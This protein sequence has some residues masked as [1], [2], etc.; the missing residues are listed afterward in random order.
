[1]HVQLFHLAH[2]QNLHRAQYDVILVCD[3]IGDTA[4]AYPTVPL[5]NV[6]IFNTLISQRRLSQHQWFDALPLHLSVP[7]ICVLMRCGYHPVRLLVYQRRR[8]TLDIDNM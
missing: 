8:R 1:M 2:A 5:R 4:S 3:E 7:F 6:D